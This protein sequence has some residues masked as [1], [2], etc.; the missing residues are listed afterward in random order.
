MLADPFQYP[1]RK[2]AAEATRNWQ[3]RNSAK[4]SFLVAGRLG[5][6]CSHYV[7]AD[8][9]AGFWGNLGGAGAMLATLAALLDLSDARNMGTT[10]RF[11]K[12]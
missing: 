8:K 10:S 6:H 5:L 12:S 7:I 3:R 1:I 11:E 2:R 4:A 9:D